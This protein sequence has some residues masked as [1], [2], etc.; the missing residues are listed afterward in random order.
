MAIQVT[1]S[2]DSILLNTPQ[3]SS[4]LLHFAY[5]PTKLLLTETSDLKPL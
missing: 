5:V 4:M 1:T 3:T 2:C